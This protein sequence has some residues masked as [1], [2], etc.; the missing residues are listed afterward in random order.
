[1]KPAPLS[2][3]TSVKY[4]YDI[5]YVRAPRMAAGG[6]K[7]AEVGDPRTMEPGA[8]L[9][10]LHPDGNG[11]GAGRAR[12]TSRSPTRTSPSTASGSTTRR[13]TTPLN[14]KGADIYK[15]HVPTRKILRLTQPEVH[16]QHRR[17]R[18]GRRRRVP[19]G[20]SST[21]APARCPAGKLAFASNRN[22]FKAP[23]P[24]LRART[25]SPCSCSSWTTT[26][27]N[28]ECIGHLNLG[29][30]LH[31][32]VAQGRPHHVQLA[33]IA[34]AA[35]PSP[36]GPLDHPPRRHATGSRCLSAFELGNGTAD[37]FHFQTQLSDG[38]IVV[39]A[40]Y[41]LNNCGFGTYFKF[42]VTAARRRTRRSARATRTTRATRRCAMAATTTAGR[43]TSASRSARTASS[44]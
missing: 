23:Q 14:H 21:W 5:V 25:R 28:V 34:G 3:D 12:A 20:A 40:Y 38:S 32:V 29:M 1:M 36:V 10:L 42:P 31:P 27:S 9:M 24:R 41:N 37:S 26:A 30:A 7:W 35:Q 39:E 2:T 43:S 15:I 22:A 44:R 13:S 8:D 18:T 11:G 16:A 6:P 17:R 4:D 19:G 33:R